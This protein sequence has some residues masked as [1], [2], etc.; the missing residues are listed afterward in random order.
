[1]KGQ[2]PHYFVRNAMPMLGEAAREEVERCMRE[3]ARRRLS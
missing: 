1:M 3:A 2:K